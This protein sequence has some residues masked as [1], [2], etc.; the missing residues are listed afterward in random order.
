MTLFKRSNPP[1]PQ[2]EVCAKCGRPSAVRPAAPQPILLQA[3][4]A[5]SFILFL[6]FADRLKSGAYLWAWSVAQILLGGLL[7]RARMRASIRIFRCSWCERTSTINFRKDT[8]SA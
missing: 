2:E 8:P 3:T 1:Q 5:V 6:F 7:I 4:F